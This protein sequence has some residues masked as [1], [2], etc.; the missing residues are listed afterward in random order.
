MKRS[1]LPMMGLALLVMALGASGRAAAAPAPGSPEAALE[2]AVAAMNQGRL[3]DY[4]AAMHPESL[5]EFHTMMTAMLDGAD[6]EGKAGDVLPLFDQAKSVAELKKLDDHQFFARFLAGVMGLNPEL[7]KTMA[8]AKTEMLGHVVEGKDKA[9]V[10]YR[11]TIES[12][13][14]SIDNITVN[15]LRRHGAKWMLLLSGETEGMVE[16]LKQRAAGKSAMPDMKASRV[17]PVGRLVHGGEAGSG[18]AYVVYR[19]VT[20]IGDSRISKIAV[21]TVKPTDP[22]WAIAHRGTHEELAGLVRKELGL[23]ATSGTDPAAGDPPPSRKTN[24]PAK[25]AMPRPRGGDAAR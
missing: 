19:L 11:L 1:L 6:K 22:G 8:G 12:N 20:P 13:G 4:T 16:M 7:K 18:P 24:P 25:K 23:D 2:H 5:K 15:S 14:K 3:G 10:I 21:L 9:H 17:E